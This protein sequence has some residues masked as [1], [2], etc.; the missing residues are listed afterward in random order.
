MSKT[1][2]LVTTQ[3]CREECLH[4]GARSSLTQN[5]DPL[6]TILPCN[7]ECPVHHPHVAQYQI[8][9]NDSGAHRRESRNWHQPQYVQLLLFTESQTHDRTVWTLLCSQG[10]RWNESIIWICSRTAYVHVHCLCRT[11]F[12]MEVHRCLFVHTKQNNWHPHLSKPVFQ[13]LFVV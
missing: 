11:L 12:P 4:T 13:R 9:T 2:L 7:P 5:Q 10:L 3:T 6:W 1:F 8:K